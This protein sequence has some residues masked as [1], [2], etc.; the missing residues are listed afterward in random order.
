MNEPDYAAD[1]VAAIEWARKLLSDDFVILDTE[2]TGL[3]V[4]D[5]V[6]QVAVIDKTGQ[7]L[8][9][10]LVKPTRPIPRIA[11]GIHG[12]TDATVA[13]APNFGQMYDALLMAI[14]GKRV[15][16]Y[17]APFDVGMLFQSEALF[18]EADQSWATIDR[19][20]WQ[21]LA[22]WEDVML[23]YAAYC[24]DWSDY[25]GNYRYQKLPGGDHS[26]LGDARATLRLLKRMAGVPNAS[27]TVPV[28]DVELS[29]YDMHFGR[30]YVDGS[31]GEFKETRLADA[32]S[33][34]VAELVDSYSGRAGSPDRHRLAL[35]WFNAWRRDQ[36]W[37]PVFERQN[38]APPDGQP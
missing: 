25:H 13:T 4:F 33:A 17:N 7:V 38:D 21:A 22:V 1:R 34:F 9:D 16:I 12:I 37:R 23:P 27:I 31:F 8:L 5:Q 30:F 15:A 32:L 36:G 28:M 29:G 35:A 19:E 26:A 6:V 3:G 10:T 24:G 14:G 20:G 18:H 2:T 11:S